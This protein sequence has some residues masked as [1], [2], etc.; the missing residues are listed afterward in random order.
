[1]KKSSL[2]FL[3]T[4]LLAF[5]I[6]IIFS[7]H[8]HHLTEAR[9]LMANILESSR[10]WIDK[11]DH[12]NVG[13][14]LPSPPPP[15]KGSQPWTPGSFFESTQDDLSESSRNWIDKGDHYNVG[16]RLPSPPPPPKGS[17][18]WTP[19]SF[20]ESTQDDLFLLSRPSSPKLSANH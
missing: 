16:G 17:Q 15:P 9:P 14:R 10:N 13:G 11:G 5:Q 19:G 4:S 1:M 2:L 18:P 12:Y 6:V 20:F 8:P 3:L 7:S